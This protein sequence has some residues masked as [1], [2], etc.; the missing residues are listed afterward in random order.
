MGCCSGKA[1]EVEP[2]DTA[3]SATKPV[4]EAEKSIEDI[5]FSQGREQREESIVEVSVPYIFPTVA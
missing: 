3:A 1:A 2:S 4:Q 5:E